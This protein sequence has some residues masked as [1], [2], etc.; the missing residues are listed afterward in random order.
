MKRAAER[1]A[2]PMPWGQCDDQEGEWQWKQHLDS[3]KGVI[4]LLSF[5]KCELIISVFP[6]QGCFVKKQF[7][8]HSKPWRIQPLLPRW[9]AHYYPFLGIRPK[10]TTRNL[11][12]P[13]GVEPGKE[14]ERWSDL[15]ELVKRQTAP[16]GFSPGKESP[17]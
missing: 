16:S 17:C 8:S 15:V 10:I 4:I 14:E 1:P 6:G 7:P 5:I 9:R 11:R 12:M 2:I 13:P 3:A